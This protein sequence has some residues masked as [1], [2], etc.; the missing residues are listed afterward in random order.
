MFYFIKHLLQSQFADAFSN[1][2][3]L[4]ELRLAIP[5]IGCNLSS[6]PSSYS[7][8]DSP[9]AHNHL[10]V[11]D[12]VRAN[13]KICATYLA[14]RLP[15]LQKVGLQYRTRTG[16]YRSEDRWL[17]YRIERLVVDDNDGM[18]VIEIRLHEVGQTWY[19]FPEV[20]KAVRFDE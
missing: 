8:F 18:P 9:H 20:W 12:C 6:S 10:Q 19:P 16:D 11:R 15:T 2:Q 5:H 13:R 1:L 4:R 17:N 14:T 7:C 3:H